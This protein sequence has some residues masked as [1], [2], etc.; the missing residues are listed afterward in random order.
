MAWSVVTSSPLLLMVF[1]IATILLV[2]SSSAHAENQVSFEPRS[3]DPS[4]SENHQCLSTH[5]LRIN[6]DE[7]VKWINHASSTV[8]VTSGTIETG[9]DGLFD[10]V[11]GPDHSTYQKFAKPGIYK[12]FSK[13]QPWING[14]IIVGSESYLS[15]LAQLKSG[16]DPNNVECNFGYELIIKKSNDRPICVSVATAE[17]LIHS[18]WAK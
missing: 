3:A 6:V 13:I 5:V 2:F 11:I 17:K 12:Y 14:K 4:C 1:G 7:T 10:E 15:P 8:T 18:G 9:P 16:I